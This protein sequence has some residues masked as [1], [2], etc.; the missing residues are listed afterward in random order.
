MRE[1]DFAS[2]VLIGNAVSLADAAKAHAYPR[3]GS[4]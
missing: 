4:N 2:C 1:F 3:S